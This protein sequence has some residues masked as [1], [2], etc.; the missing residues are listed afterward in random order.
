M[1]ESAYHRRPSLSMS[2]L[3]KKGLFFD[4]LPYLFKKRF[5]SKDLDH[6]TEGQHLDQ[7]FGLPSLV[8][9]DGAA[10]GVGVFHTL[11]FF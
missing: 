11:H 10:V 8:I 7:Q 6:R 5:R 1:Q 4:P 3:C 2:F 9:V